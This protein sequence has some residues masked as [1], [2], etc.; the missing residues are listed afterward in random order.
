[1]REHPLVIGE[2][3]HILN[4]SIAGFKI[5]DRKVDSIR[6]I[7]LACYYKIRQPSASFSHFSRGDFAMESTSF[8]NPQSATKTVD[9]VQIV[10]YC[11]MPTHFHFIL[12]QLAP[13]GI[14][15][16]MNNV[17]NAYSRYF[18]IKYHRKG[19]LWEGR[20]RS[21]LVTTQEQFLH[22]TRYIHL[23]PV[24]ANLVGKPEEWNA[25]SYNEYFSERDDGQRM[26]SFDG[27]VD[28][29]KE[30]YVKFVN[31]RI[32]YQKM[33]AIIKNLILE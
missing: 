22:L 14:S 7:D 31:E 27:I 10:A 4:R 24:T 18:N 8:D 21:K 28:M 9:L 32:A 17:L 3:Y 20:F 29:S 5:F 30:V 2:T 16:F 13:M 33:L 25:S 26:C 23:N 11:L 19:P 12:K 1:M 6:M 15:V